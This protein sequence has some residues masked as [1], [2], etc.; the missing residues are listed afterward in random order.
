MYDVVTIGDSFEDLFIFPRDARILTST[1]FKSKKSLCF[2]YGDK[3]EVEKIECHIGGSATNTVMNFSKLGFKCVL[4]TSVGNDS[5][6]EK[7]YRYFVDKG[8]DTSQIKKSSTA[9]TNTSVILSFEGD[10]TILTYHG[11]ADYSNFRP[12]KDLKTDW[13]YVAPLGKHSGIVENR[14]IENIAKTGSGL[15]WNPGSYQLSKGIR[16]YRHF[17]R[18][19]NIIFLNRE[20]AMLFVDLPGKQTIE[21]VMKT[22]HSFG[23]KIVVVTNGDKGAMCYDGDLF[24][25]I[26]TTDD[27][28]IDATG[29]GDSFASSFSAVIIKNCDIKKPQAYVPDREVVEESLKSG[30][31]VSG[32]VV[33]KIGAHSGLLTLRE[34]SERMGKLVKLQPSV[35]TK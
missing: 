34:I 14:I 9:S 2:C 19:C 23:V 1:D 22:L 30:I 21:E 7:I 15:I 17:L 25:Q 31:I 28:R 32:S 3:V 33:S 26:E 13:Y 4:I 12:K 20:E 35:Y 18:F 5:Q 27:E 11:T 10:R 24:Y 29:A 8:I 16:N 6:G